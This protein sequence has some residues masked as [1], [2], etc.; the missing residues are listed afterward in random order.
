MPQ[1]PPKYAI[2]RW[3]IQHPTPSV[4][5]AFRSLRLATTALDFDPHFQIASTDRPCLGRQFKHVP[6]VNWIWMY[7]INVYFETSEMQTLQL[8]VMKQY[9]AVDLLIMRLLQLVELA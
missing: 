6:C 3:K 1:N 2:S 9:T 4:P 7:V 5:S 8:V